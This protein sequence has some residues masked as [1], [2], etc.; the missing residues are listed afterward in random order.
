MT[1]LVRLKNTGP[2]SVMQL[3]QGVRQQP[4]P[5]EV[6]IDHDA[7]GVNYLDVMQRSGSAPL[8][9]PTGLGLEGAG[10]VAEVGSEVAN[11]FP[12]DRVAYI[13]GAVGSYASGRVYPADRLV[14][15]PDDVSFREA[16]SILFKGVTAQYLLKTTYQVGPGTRILL[17]GA[18]GPVG[19]IL[20]RWA[21]H[22]GATVF[23]VV[24]RVASIETA[25]AAGADEVFVWDERDLP[26]EVAR[27]TGGRKMDVVY[28]GVGRTTFEASLDSLRPRGLMVSFGASS[29]LPEPISVATLNGKGSL[30]LTRPSLAAHVAD[31]TEYQGR[32]QDVLNAFRAGIVKSPY[33]QTIPLEQVQK[34][35]ELLEA[36]K[37]GG[38]L[39]LQ[40]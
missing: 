23:G 2:A 20:C 24:S 32:M 35:H 9:L 34:A 3:E 4:G 22:L 5:T 17:Y 19:Q 31:L 37:A 28:D 40:P 10:H 33:S 39:I 29:G 12:G 38:S 8:P 11:V 15:L 6:W 1:I 13:M 36:G 18:A 26:S 7:I 30:Y 25:R 14:K 21:T 27:L 16:A